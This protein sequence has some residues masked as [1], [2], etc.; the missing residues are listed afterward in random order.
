M[1]VFAVPPTEH[2]KYYVDV[3]SV[4]CELEQPNEFGVP[5]GIVLFSGEVLKR[6][7]AGV[8]AMRIASIEFMVM[9]LAYFS[10]CAQYDSL[11]A[12]MLS[13]R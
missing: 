13:E 3:P 10:L 7:Q 5:T 6:S 8:L 9:T 4:C 11:S 2:G 1:E 12:L